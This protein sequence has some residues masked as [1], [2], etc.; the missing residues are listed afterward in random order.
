M[1]KKEYLGLFVFLLLLTTPSIGQAMHIMEG[2]LPV[3]WSIAWT[4][5]SLPFLLFGIKRVNE[6][7]KEDTN[8][9]VLL[10]RKSV[11]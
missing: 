7:F 10:D 11:V 8:K 4:L 5:I 1:K 3:G 6:I 9:K 2:F